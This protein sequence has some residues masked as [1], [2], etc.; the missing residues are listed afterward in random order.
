M[1]KGCRRALI[2]L[3]LLKSTKGVEKKANMRLNEANNFNGTEFTDCNYTDRNHR[4]AANFFKDTELPNHRFNVVLIH[5]R[6]C[7]T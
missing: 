7:R 6:H 3:T 1:F 5:V 2:A 4:L